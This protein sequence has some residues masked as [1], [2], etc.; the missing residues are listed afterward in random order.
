MPGKIWWLP[1]IILLIL[2]NLFAVKFHK[3]FD[4]TNEKRFTIS[5][6]VKKLLINIDSVVNIDVFLKGEL[7]SGFRKLA[8]TT[9]ELLQEFKEI[10]GNKIQYRFISADEVMEGTG[11]TYA[12]T[13]AAMNAQ[14]INLKVQLKSG[15]QSQLV[16]PSAL[17]Y[18]KGNMQI[19][20]LYPGT[21]FLITPAELNSAEALLE[22]NI[23]DAIQKLTQ[24]VK[25]MIAYSVGNGEP[26]GV[27]IFDLVENTLKKNYS[28][29]TIDINSQPIIPDTFK[30]VMV[31]KPAVSFTETEKIK[32]DQYIMRGGKVLWCI[33]RL[34]AEMDSLR[35][36]NQ[37]VAYDRN[38]NLEDLFFK[39]G[40]RINPDLVMDL[41][42]D[43]LP[44][45][46]NGNGQFEFLHWNY[47]P[48]F[49]S[50]SNHVINKN[51]G[52]VSGRFVNSMDTVKANEILKT[53]LLSSSPNS[54][55]ISAPALISGEENR[56]APEDEQFKN[57]DI[58]AAV[59]LEGKFNSLYANRMPV[60]LMDSM[61]KYGT[62]YQRS[63]SNTNKMIVISD[64]DVVLNGVS[65]N[66]P[67]PMGV[68]PFTSGSQYEYQ[69]A[70]KEFMLNCLSYLTNN[71]GLTEARAKDYTL[72]LLD[73]KKISEQR[74]TW[75]LVN[76][77]L[78]VLLIFLF[79]LLYQFWRKKE[80]SN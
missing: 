50:K 13:L 10:G 63:C 43:F 53:I 69:F 78:P 31:V 59:L 65:Q 34:E 21:K 41:Q 56:N 42:C 26:T 8:A 3:R 60:A 55:V 33:D 68:N 80:Y 46:V 15:E 36:K 37:V 79:G 20:N 72:R 39:Y 22:Y 70:N 18:Y 19:I 49:Q 45:D 35:V 52:L 9:D 5:S 30:L 75:Q 58:P 54:R 44:F 7:P 2:L 74:L 61:E 6:P 25:P 66:N 71:S 17:I 40:V 57:K 62:P 64:G 23:A 24:Q 12:D 48:L 28:L 1:I 14:P 47:F 76:I 38:L 4:L 67:L 77:V 27:N 11:K 16:F 29:F 51:I 32:L 73:P